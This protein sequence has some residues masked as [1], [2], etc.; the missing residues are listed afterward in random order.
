MEANFFE[1]SFGNQNAISMVC[2]TFMLL[3]FLVDYEH[4]TARTNCENNTWF[5]LIGNGIYGVVSSLFM[6]SDCS[7]V[8]WMT[9]C[10]GT[11]CHSFT[12]SLR[13]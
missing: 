1:V 6:S 8:Q 5:V 13:C 10:E 2:L 3:F 12:R 9:Y 7:H 4:K 11:I